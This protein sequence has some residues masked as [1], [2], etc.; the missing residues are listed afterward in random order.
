MSLEHR[1]ARLE[2]QLRTCAT[3]HTPLIC[4]SC[5]RFEAL[6]GAQAGLLG[7]L[8][9]RIGGEAFTPAPQHPCCPRC[10]GIRLC[11]LCNGQ[12]CL[13]TAETAQ[14]VGVLEGMHHA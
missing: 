9:L 4:Q 11:P 10:R 14:L 12:R 13:T 6:T 5:S 3:H 8:F 1:M 2:A 7:A